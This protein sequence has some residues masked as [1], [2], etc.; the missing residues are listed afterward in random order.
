MIPRRCGGVCTSRRCELRHLAGWAE[1]M[2]TRRQI[3][4]SIDKVGV[5]HL[6]LQ[7]LSPHLVAG[8]RQY[9]R[10]GEVELMALFQCGINNRLMSLRLPLRGGKS[11]TIISVYVPPTT[12]PRLDARPAGRAGN[13]GGT[14]C[15]WVGRPSPHYL[16]N[17]DSSI[18]SQETSRG[19]LSRPSTISD[20]AITRLPQVESNADLNPPPS[21]H[22]LNAAVQQLSSGKAPESDAIPADI[23]KHA[24]PQ[25]MALF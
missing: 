20:A 14:G 15:R 23:Y 8:S 16:R 11:V 18:T 10:V 21:F 4:V 9:P 6:R 7:Q 1:C 5:R 13:K 3:N 17:V 22:E 12:S 19:V 24:D 25:L 2:I